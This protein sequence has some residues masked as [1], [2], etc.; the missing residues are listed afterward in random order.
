MLDAFEYW[1]DLTPGRPP[2]TV[3]E[4]ASTAQ[5]FDDR[6]DKPMAAVTRGDVVGYRDHLLRDGL[7][8]ATVRK[9]IGF[10]SAM[11][12]TQVD[13]TTI[14]LDLNESLSHTIVMSP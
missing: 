8:A 14:G 13:A 9:R 7:A 6:I 3:L 1:R 5:Q 4:F 12:Q 2:R 11:L 10:V